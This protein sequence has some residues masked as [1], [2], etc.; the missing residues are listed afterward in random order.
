[1]A[2]ILSRP[3]CVKWHISID[4]KQSRTDTDDALDTEQPTNHCLKKITMIADTL[5]GHQGRQKKSHKYQLESGIK[6]WQFSILVSLMSVHCV[7]I[8]RQPY[9]HH[10]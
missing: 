2:D 6:A 9:L 1:M 7:I 4:V 8:T 10:W 3:Q 5:L